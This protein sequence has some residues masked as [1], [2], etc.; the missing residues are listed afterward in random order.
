MLSKGD[1]YR[2]TL[3]GFLEYEWQQYP[4]YI[5]LMEKNTFDELM[6][7]LVQERGI[8]RY[9]SKRLEWITRVVNAVD[10]VYAEAPEDVKQLARVKYWSEDK[11]N[12]QTIAERLGISMQKAVRMNK[13]MIFK[14]ADI[15]GFW[16]DR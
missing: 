12:W 10:K 6:Q 8:R 7:K 3:Q 13:A 11:T 4:G 9:A 14:T 15:M 2:K 5:E 16:W 1:Q